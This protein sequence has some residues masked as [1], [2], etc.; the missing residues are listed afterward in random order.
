MAVAYF[1]AHAPRGS[2]PILNRGELAVLYS[3]VFLYIAYQ[4]DGRWSATGLFRRLRV[5]RKSTRAT[6]P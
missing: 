6:T 3:F 1:K 5:E 4:G 2:W